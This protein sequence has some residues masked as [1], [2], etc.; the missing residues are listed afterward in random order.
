[1]LAR[2]HFET[3]IFDRRLLERD[4]YGGEGLRKT[5]PGYIVLMET[6]ARSTRRAIDQLIFEQTGMSAQEFV[7][8]GEKL[9]VVGEL[10]VQARN[11]DHWIQSVENNSLQVQA[12][13]LVL[14]SYL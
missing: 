14:E 1:M 7:K 8:Q 4:H 3:A 12:K 2:K 10:S 9:R 5:R 6:L 11:I 13:M